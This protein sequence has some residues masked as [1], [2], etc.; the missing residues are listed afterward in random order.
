MVKD[1]MGLVS[2]DPEVGKRSLPLGHRV[3]G[4]D[5]QEETSAVGALPLELLVPTRSSA[6]AVQTKSIG[7]RA[8]KKSAKVVAAAGGRPSREQ[9]ED[10]LF[11][12]ME[13]LTEDEVST[14]YD[15]LH[16]RGVEFDDVEVLTN[17]R[18]L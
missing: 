5:V 6:Q 11:V 13:E 10:D 12:L 1:E 8:R 16:V 3:P 9:Q 17:S 15:L 4:A 14:V 7:A 2:K 18:R